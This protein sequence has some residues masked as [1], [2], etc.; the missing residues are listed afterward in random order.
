[1]KSSLNFKHF[2]AL[3]LLFAVSASFAQNE[4]QGTQTDETY[5]NTTVIYTK[6]KSANDAAILAQ[7]DNSYGIGD[8]VRITVAQP[9]PAASDMLASDDPGVMFAAKSAP[10]V[11]P[12]VVRSAPKSMATPVQ[13]P[14]AATVETSKKTVEPAVNK[15]SRT[16][17]MGSIYRLERVYFDA[18]QSELK[19]ESEEELANLLEFMEAHPAAVIEVRGHT[20]NLMWPNTEFANELSTNRAKVVAD[21]LVA[22]GIAA[23]RVQH[24]GYGWTMPIL[25]NINAEGRKKNQR[26]EVKVLNM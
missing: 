10:V 21:W 17:R 11:T 23:E 7:L 5:G 16:V 9:K 25:P 8:V 4:I 13:K 12:K 14:V 19:A 6:D 20:N 18:N 26:V 24:K 1:M 3:P 22:K 2:L 15:I